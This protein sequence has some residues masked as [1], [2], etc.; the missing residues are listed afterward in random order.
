M[1]LKKKNK[2]SAQFN[3]SSLTD[4]IFLLLIFFMLTSSLVAPNA[5]NIKF[6]GKSQSSTISNK[7]IPEV[8]VQRNGKY[9]FNG[10]AISQGNLDRMLRQVSRQ[11]SKRE[12]I[13]IYPNP[14]APVESVAFV[15]DAAMRYHLNAII[16]SERE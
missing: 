13:T 5:L 7:K 9:L 4:I 3:M 8:R 6:P 2:V 16:P 11:T 10:T 12:D 1:G 15:M 14:N